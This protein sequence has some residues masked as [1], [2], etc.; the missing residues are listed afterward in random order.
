MPHLSRHDDVADL[1]VRSRPQHVRRLHQGQRGEDLPPVQ[2]AAFQNSQL[3]AGTTDR[4]HAE[5]S[6]NVVLFRR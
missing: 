3:P 2:G 5:E 6:E 1:A 4:E